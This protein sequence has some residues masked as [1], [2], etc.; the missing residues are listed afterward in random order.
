MLE[1]ELSRAS[2]PKTGT[3]TSKHHLESRFFLSSPTDRST[4]SCV[5]LQVNNIAPTLLNYMLLPLMVKSAAK[6]AEGGRNDFKPHLTTVSSALHYN[7]KHLTLDKKAQGGLLERMN[8]VKKFGI[9]RYDETKGQA[10]PGLPSWSSS[11]EP[12]D[13]LTA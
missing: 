6:S 2:S 10:T 8:Q 13:L 3:R 11:L 4:V 12:E 9:V 5:R 7:I 1:F